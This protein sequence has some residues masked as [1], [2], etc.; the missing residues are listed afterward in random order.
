M[1][2]AEE[3]APVRVERREGRELRPAEGCEG[4]V[5]GGGGRQGTEVGTRKA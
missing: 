2:A 1:M 4:S 5:C 3:R